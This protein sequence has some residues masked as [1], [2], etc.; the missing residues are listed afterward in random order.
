MRT[1]SMGILLVSAVRV[2]TIATV[3]AAVL[4]PKPAVAQQ[5]DEWRGSFA[6]FYL[7]AAGIDGEV[8]ARGTT[9]PVS[10]EFADA[11]DKLSAAFSFHFEAQKGRLGLFSDLC[12]I[13][14]S[15]EATFTIPVLPGTTI[16]GNVEL[17]NAIFEIGGS[18]LLK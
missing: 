13:G 5:S 9:E 2:L 11:A 15:S 6:P 7:W 17:S 12:Y 14:L 18:Y 1:P 3:T 8:T 4:A 16:P 10:L